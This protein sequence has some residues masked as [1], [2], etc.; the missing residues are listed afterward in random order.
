MLIMQWQSLLSLTF[1]SA[2][3]INNS[4]KL[5]NAAPLPQADYRFESSPEKVILADNS[6][7]IVKQS[8]PQNLLQQLNLTAEQR[9]KINQIHQK[10]KQQMSKKRHA[11]AL[12]QQQLSDMM[13]GTEAI[14]SIRNKNQQL[15]NLRQEI[16]AL[17]FETMLATR[18]ILTL[19]QRKKFRTLVES[20]ESP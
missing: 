13:V 15:V 5:V 10:Y 8:E 9:Q 1:I 19:Q 11:L 3:I 4:W 6:L 17:R 16:G 2:I 12:L 7:E 20:Q 14:E 18:E